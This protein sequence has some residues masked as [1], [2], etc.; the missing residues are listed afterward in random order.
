MTLTIDLW[1]LLVLSIFGFIGAFVVF[2]IILYGLAYVFDRN[3]EDRRL[4]A[5][6]QEKECPEYIESEEEKQAPR[7]DKE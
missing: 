2:W 6:K 3:R 7:P 1:L 5:K 4:K